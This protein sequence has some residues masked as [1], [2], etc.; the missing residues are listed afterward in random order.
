[1]PKLNTLQWKNI[2]SDEEITLESDLKLFQILYGFQ[3]YEAPS[4]EIGKIMGFKAKKPQG[5]VNLQIGRY[6]K[7][8]AK[9]FDIDFTV[10]TNQKFKF[11]DLYFTGRD[12]GN[13]FY[14][15]LK[16][17]LREALE[18]LNLTDEFYFAI[19]VQA[20]E[21][22]KLK[23]GAVKSILVNSYERNSKAREICIQHWLPVCSVCEFNFQKTYGTLG[24]DF[25]H[26]HHL[27]PINEIGE[28]YEIDPINDLRPVCPNCH[29]MIHKKNPPLKIEELKALINENKST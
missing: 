11:W 28:E 27:N 5:P 8:I 4:S 2:L 7:R 29:A 19:E 9:K 13:K 6:A 26:V 1:M 10:R 20:T 12:L 24:K 16:D 3:N 14:W 25:I 21:N 23:E 22:L 18:E 17:E 15:K